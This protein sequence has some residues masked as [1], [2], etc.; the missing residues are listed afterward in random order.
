MTQPDVLIIGAGIIGLTLGYELLQRGQRVHVLDQSA[1][2]QG[3]TRAAAGMLATDEELSEPLHALAAVSRALYPKLVRQLFDETGL[4]SGYLELPFQLRQKDQTVQFERVGQIDPRLLVRALRQAIDQRGGV[5][6]EQMTV[7][8]LLRDKHTVTGV[9]TSRGPQVGRQVVI[10]SGRGSEPLLQTIGIPIDTLPVKGECLSV[11]L[12]TGRLE[13]T[14]FHE[15]VYLVPKADGRII[16]GATEHVGEESTTVNAGSVSELLAAAIEVYP[17]IRDAALI[18][19]WSGV[20]PQTRDG[21]PYLGRVKGVDGL[22]VATGHH[23]H[24]ILL[25]PV[26]AQ[27]LADCVM[28]RKPE[29]TLEAFCCRRHEEENTCKSD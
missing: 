15:T 11:R 20:R 27:V 1:V 2:G 8:R 14:L 9:E 17:A 13:Q 26:T 23:R 4:T 29:V 18:D 7:L 21:L 5:I 3:A 16:I 22:S 12:T 6:E 24:G 10:A 19:I 28:N 25:A